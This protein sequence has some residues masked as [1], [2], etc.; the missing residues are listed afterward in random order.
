MSGSCNNFWNRGM[1][2]S[3][4]LMTV[5]PSERFRRASAS[6]RSRPW[7]ISLPIWLSY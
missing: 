6:S 4:P 3:T 5:S 7:T 1:V 2:V